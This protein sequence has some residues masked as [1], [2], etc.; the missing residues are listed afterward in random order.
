MGALAAV[1]RKRRGFKD[2]GLACGEMIARGSVN[3]AILPYRPLTQRTS[4]CRPV[5]GR[6]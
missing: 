3:S 6:R 5:D 1:E 4:R 2:G